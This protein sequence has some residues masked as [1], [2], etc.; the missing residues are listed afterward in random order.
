MNSL[1]KSLISELVG[2][3]LVTAV[4]GGGFKPPTKKNTKNAVVVKYI[5]GQKGTLVSCNP[6]GPDN[7]EQLIFSRIFKVIGS[8]VHA[9]HTNHDRIGVVVTKGKT[10][11]DAITSANEAAESFN[12]RIK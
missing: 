9:P 3:N 1:T 5:T 2:D 4:Y 8:K 7:I 12:I 11:N 10:L 6:E